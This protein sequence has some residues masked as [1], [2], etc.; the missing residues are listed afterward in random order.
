MK[1]VSKKVR[2]SVSIHSFELAVVLTFLPDPILAVAPKSPMGHGSFITNGLEYK[3]KS[4]K[5]K[6]PKILCFEPNNSFLF[7][8]TVQKCQ[9]ES[10]FL[11]MWFPTPGPRRLL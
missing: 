6:D 10:A 9:E 3:T 5:Q 8:L 11:N 2:K 1:I 7:H 4:L